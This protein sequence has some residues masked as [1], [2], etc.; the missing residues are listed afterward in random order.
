MT[1][2]VEASAEYPVS[3]AVAWQAYTNH[4]RWK[5]WTFMT[6]SYLDKK[7]EPDPNGVGAVRVLGSGGMNSYEE[8]TAFQ[9]PERLEYR[10]VKGGLPFKGHRAE[11]IFEPLG[12]GDD[13]AGGTRIIWRCSFDSKIPGLGWLFWL[14]TRAVYRS[15][16]DA[17]KRFP[18]EAKA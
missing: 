12:H 5:E 3:P 6:V 1:Y 9:P 7:G 11:V 18:F 4:S 17:F 13:S 15:T 14:I 10:V 8:I 2:Q 16:L